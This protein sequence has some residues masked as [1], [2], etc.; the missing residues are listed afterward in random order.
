MADKSGINKL[1]SYLI[2]K[3][4]DLSSDTNLTEKY[5]EHAHCPRNTQKP[6]D[7]LVRFLHSNIQD[8]IIIIF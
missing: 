8:S 3:I 2:S 6:R 1:T 5:I 4:N 7:I